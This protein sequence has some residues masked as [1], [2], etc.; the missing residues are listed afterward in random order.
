MATLMHLKAK[1]FIKYHATKCDDMIL[2]YFHAYV[3]GNKLS[4]YKYL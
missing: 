1:P 2:I 3:P 4:P